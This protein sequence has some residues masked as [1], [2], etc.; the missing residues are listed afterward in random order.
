MNKVYRLVW[1]KIH[2]LWIPVVE[3]TRSHKKGRFKTRNK[4]ARTLEGQAPPKLQPSLVRLFVASVLSI[5][6]PKVL[7]AVVSNTLPTGANITSGAA[8]IST[9]GSNMLIQ[10][11]TDKL[12][13]N[14]TS[15]DIGSSASVTF[16]QPSSSSIALNR[17]SAQNPTQIFGQLNANGHVMLLNSSGIVFTQGSQIN[18]G[19]IT[20]STLDISDNDFLSDNF[21]F[22]GSTGEILNQGSITT[23]SG[24]RVAFIAKRV[25]NQGTITTPD[26]TTSLVAASDVTLDL[27]G[28]GTT[29]ITINQ[30]VVDALVENNQIIKTDNGLVL[31]SARALDTLTRS[32]VNNTGVIE[33]TSLTEK[34]GRIILEG[35]DIRLSKTSEIDASG[36]TGGG[37][38]LIGGDWQG[39]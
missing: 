25:K 22:T 2:N 32:A 16:D 33:A 30:G 23:M 9:T 6:A 38:V 26:G 37:E 17:I 39:S 8:T 21:R 24:G 13:T 31:L 28:D 19:A 27:N 3:L 34:G 15:F 7:A 20:A 29:S 4:T 1:S 14:W 35:D 11:Q 18:V 12:I 10:Q 36:A 5:A